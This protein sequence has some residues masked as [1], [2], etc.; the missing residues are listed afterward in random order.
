[1]AGFNHLAV[2]QAYQQ[3]EPG[4][5]ALAPDELYVNEDYFKEMG[6]RVTSSTPT[7]ARYTDATANHGAGSP[8]PQGTIG[9]NLGSSCSAPDD[10]A[11]KSNLTLFA[12]YHE[13]DKQDD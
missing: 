3:I 10:R 13:E 4:E 8:A 12:S 2:R 9:G 6:T 11:R 7:P 5:V 1:V